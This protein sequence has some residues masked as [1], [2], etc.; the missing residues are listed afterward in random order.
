ME[1]LDNKK[2]IFIKDADNT[3]LNV[4]YDGILYNNIKLIRCFPQTFKDGLISI[5]KDDNTELGIIKDF[6]GFDDNMKNIINEEL[7]L[8]YY[9]PEILKITKK[10]NKNRFVTLFCNTSSGD[11]QI[12]LNDDLT[13]HVFVYNKDSL[14]IKDCDESYYIIKDFKNKKDKYIKYLESYI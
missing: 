5:K 4:N 13:N 9:I 7:N 11:K 6:E 1:Y 8:R 10:S 12:R 2:L 14:L 3:M